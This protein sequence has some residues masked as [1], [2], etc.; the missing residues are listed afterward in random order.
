MAA[1]IDASRTDTVLVLRSAE[2]VLERRADWD[3][4]AFGHTDARLDVFLSVVE[5][6][7]EVIR[8]HVLVHERDGETAGILV[9]R[10]EERE[11]PAR[12]GYATV[13]RPRVRALTVVAGGAAGDPHSQ[14]LLAG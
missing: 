2:E 8:P 11:L 4:L 10:L 13:Y 9:G 6:L 5:T 1:T 7:P 14:S 3:G 12:F